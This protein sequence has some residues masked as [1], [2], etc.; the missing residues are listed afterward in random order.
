MVLFD[1]ESL[2]D[3]LTCRKAVTHLQ[4]LQM[5]IPLDM[6]KKGGGSPPPSRVAF[7]AAEQGRERSPRL[8][9]QGINRCLQESVL[10][11]F[12][13]YSGRLSRIHLQVM[14]LAALRPRDGDR[15][16]P[17]LRPIRWGGRRSAHPHKTA[18][19]HV[20]YRLLPA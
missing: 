18:R 14:N 16:F 4:I 8:V 7:G 9:Q 1:Q 15:L 3:F 2:V 10:P 20:E 17:Q 13:L 6:S 12:R 5:D 19:L 11:C